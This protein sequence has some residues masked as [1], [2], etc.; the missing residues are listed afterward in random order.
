VCCPTA[1]EVTEARAGSYAATGVLTPEPTSRRSRHGGRHRGIMPSSLSLE[2][3][4][5]EDVFL[6]IS[7]RE[8]R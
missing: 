2:A 3:R 7:G 4:S 6:D 8:I 5:L 1:I